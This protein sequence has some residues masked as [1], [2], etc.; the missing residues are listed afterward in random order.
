MEQNRMEDTEVLWTAVMERAKNPDPRFLYAVKTT[1]IYCR[2]DCPSRRP[3]RQNIAV[4]ASGGHAE[5]D[6]FRA[7]LRCRPSARSPQE[8]TVALVAQACRTIKIA[9]EKP[10]L[11]GLAK[12][13]DLSAL[14]FQH[15][16]GSVMGSRPMLAYRPIGWRHSATSWDQKGSVD[17]VRDI[18]RPNVVPCRCA[19]LRCEQYCCRHSLSPGRAV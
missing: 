8:E 5:A 19:G 6:G 13:F 9:E 3:K 4:Y 10:P 18:R 16:L 1:G 2:P 12:K 15:A 17:H 11:E 7:C 14:Y